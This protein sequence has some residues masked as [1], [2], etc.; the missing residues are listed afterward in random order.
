MIDNLPVNEAILNQ[1]PITYVSD[2][3]DKPP[4]TPSD[5]INVR[6]G[7]SEKLTAENTSGSGAYFQV[8][9]LWKQSRAIL[10]HFWNT[11]QTEYLHY[12]RERS[13]TYKFRQS[14]TK[15]NPQIGR[16]VLIKEPNTKRNQWN[17]AKVIELKRSADDE[18]CP[19]VLQLPSRRKITRSIG[20]LYPFE[21][22]PMTASDDNEDN[23]STFDEIESISCEVIEENP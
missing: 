7:E 3:L 9:H 18:I 13:E 15:E 23:G 10:D 6:F 17:V 8:L 19:V 4:L 12:L 14:T 2:E 5:L 16:L 21:I 22:E 20:N 1:W 11:W